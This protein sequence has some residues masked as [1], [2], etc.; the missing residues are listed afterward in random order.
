MQSF[1]HIVDG[2]Q[3]RCTNNRSQR[4]ATKSCHH[5]PSVRM[6]TLQTAEHRVGFPCSCSS[7]SE[8]GRVHLQKRCCQERSLFSPDPPRS[9]Q[10]PPLA[11]L[12]GRRPAVNSLN[13]GAGTHRS[14]PNL[15]LGAALS[16][17]VVEG[18]RVPLGT[19]GSQNTFRC[20]CD[21]HMMV[22]SLH[23]RKTA[24]RCVP[25]LHPK[26]AHA[27]SHQNTRGSRGSP[28]SV[29]WALIPPHS[30]LLLHISLCKNHSRNLRRVGSG[31][32]D[33]YSRRLHAGACVGTTGYRVAKR[34]LASQAYPQKYK[35]PLL[36]HPKPQQDSCLVSNWSMPLG[37][38]WYHILK[39]SCPPRVSPP[40]VFLASPECSCHPGPALAAPP[41]SSK[42]PHLCA[43]R[44][45]ESMFGAASRL[46]N[47]AA[48]RA[49]CTSNGRGFTCFFW[50]QLRC[51][52]E[53]TPDQSRGD[54]VL[55]TAVGATDCVSL[56]SPL[57][58][59]V[60]VLCIQ[61]SA[62]SW[63]LLF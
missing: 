16:E 49:N 29:H 12:P 36:G 25:L 48:A 10:N 62:L 4:T 1:E 15:T 53:S 40:R 46:W 52:V 33:R 59:Q 17:D 27:Y 35:Q 43:E 61:C 45:R 8:D 39:S 21:H 44:G 13:T 50:L 58:H 54:G 6:T 26:V 20:L 24:T 7:V 18:E 14:G 19:L 31:N 37:R 42:G 56:K 41:N 51:G 47:W 2:A 60:P 55:P 30:W 34:R 22:T 11:V 57:L 28:D 9:E 38:S 63:D 23:H 32:P 5:D 3:L